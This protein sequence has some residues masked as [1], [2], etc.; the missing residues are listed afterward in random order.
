MHT[1]TRVSAFTFVAVLLAGPAPAL[2]RGAAAPAIRAD[3]GAARLVQA[4]VCR[5]RMGP[6]ATQRRAYEVRRMAIARGYQVSGVWGQGG[7]IANSPTTRGYYFNI[8]YNC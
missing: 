6:Y 3:S 5:H 7:P 1:L 4:R 8:F 2:P